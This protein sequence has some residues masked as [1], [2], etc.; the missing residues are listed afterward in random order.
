MLFHIV[1]PSL[2]SFTSINIATATQVKLYSKSALTYITL[3]PYGHLQTLGDTLASATTFNVNTIIGG[4]TLQSI[5]NNGYTSAD[6]AG[7][8]SLI[9]NRATASG[10]ETFMF[11]AQ[12]GGAYA[13]LVSLYIN[14]IENKLKY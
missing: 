4:Y 13:I 11:L 14:S 6:G 8:G 3:D 5:A 12:P 2:P 1:A 7:S 10:W 9:A